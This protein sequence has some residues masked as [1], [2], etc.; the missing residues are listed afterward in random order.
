[1]KDGRRK[2]FIVSVLVFLLLGGSVSIFFMIKGVDDLKDRPG[3]SFEYSSFPKKAMFALLKNTG[4]VDGEKIDPKITAFVKELEKKIFPEFSDENSIASPDEQAEKLY[5]KSA[6]SSSAAP[7]MP[8]E[9]IKSSISGGGTMASGG[10]TK[11][12]GLSGG[13]SGSGPS[14][15]LTV[16]GSSAQ[17]AAK[18]Q[19]SQ[20]LLS[21]L[22]YMSSNI[23]EGL[24]SGSSSQA[25]FKW[26]QSYVGNMGG[27]KQGKYSEAVTNLDKIR[28]EVVDLKAAETGGLHAPEPGEPKS[29][30]PNSGK[31]D[32]VKKSLTDQMKKDMAKGVVSSM[33]SG[34]SN[35]MSG[36]SNSQGEGEEDELGKKAKET[37]DSAVDKYK[38][39][40]NEDVVKTA[41][42]SCTDLGD[43]CNQVNLSGSVMAAKYSNGD[44]LIVAQKDDQVVVYGCDFLGCRSLPNN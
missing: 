2:V 43:L 4:F 39:Y 13:F 33:F 5:P 32:E 22:D 29:D 42:A 11:T 10:G 24:R 19:N 21:R 44:T 36:N 40:P 26:D 27:S 28:G 3:F 12:E 1:M 23:K 16:S 20:K 41:N 31:D 34:L 7:Y 30:N 17:S 14:Q 37:F 6:S 8:S 18:S 38:L 35:S 25:K 9:K 15:G